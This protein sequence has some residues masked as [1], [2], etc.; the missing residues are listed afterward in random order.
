MSD[1]TAEL[2]PAYVWTCDDCGLDNFGR[3]VRLEPESIDLDDLPGHLDADDIREWIAGGGEGEFLI[4]PERVTC[5]HC[6]ATYDAE[7]VCD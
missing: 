3:M 4:S 6:G 1:R 7:Y 2:I 5:P